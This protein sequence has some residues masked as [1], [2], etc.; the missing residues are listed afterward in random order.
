MTPDWPPSRDSWLF[1]VFALWGG[2]ANYVSTVRRGHRTFSLIE[3]IGELVVSGFSGTLV[4]AL[5]VAYDIT[6]WLAIALVGVGGHF[7]SRTVFLV[8]KY[9]KARF[10]AQ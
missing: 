2:V 5:C 7:G 4:Y 3:L 9:I 6:E 8:E 10:D 1:I